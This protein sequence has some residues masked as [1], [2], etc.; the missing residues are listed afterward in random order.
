MSTKLDD[1]FLD[2]IRRIESQPQSKKE[3]GMNT[4]AWIFLAERQLDIEELRCPLSSR[5]G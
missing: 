1:A 5:P 2:T 4:L 3:Q